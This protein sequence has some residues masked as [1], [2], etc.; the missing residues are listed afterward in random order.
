[1]GTSHRGSHQSRET[2][3]LVQS[4]GV[5]NLL[6]LKNI[7]DINDIINPLKHN[8]FPLPSGRLS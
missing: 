6:K 1:M 7:N 5:R 8:P 2:S 4:L 3:K